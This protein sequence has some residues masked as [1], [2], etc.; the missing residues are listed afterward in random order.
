MRL[1]F[2][3]I[4]AA[5]CSVFVYLDFLHCHCHTLSNFLHLEKCPSGFECLEICYNCFRIEA[6]W[7]N[8]YQRLMCYVL[9]TVNFWQN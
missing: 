5:T 3:A 8:T 6:T 7:F 9:N 2:L 1:I 4:V